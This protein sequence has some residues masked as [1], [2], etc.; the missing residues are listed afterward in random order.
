[1][2]ARSDRRLALTIGAVLSAFFVICSATQ[3]ASWTIGSV[4]RDVHE[5]IPGDRKSVV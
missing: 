1:M 3:V 4:N 2:T 5:V